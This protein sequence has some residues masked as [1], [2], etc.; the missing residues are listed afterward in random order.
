M[1]I[2]FENLFTSLSKTYYKQKFYKFQSLKRTKCLH[3]WETWLAN[4]DIIFLSIFLSIEEWIVYTGN[5]GLLSGIFTG[6]CELIKCGNK[7]INSPFGSCI[8]LLVNF[9]SARVDLFKTMIKY[10][11][12][13]LT[14]NVSIKCN[15]CQLNDLSLYFVNWTICD[16][17]SFVGWMIKAWSLSVD[18]LCFSFVCRLSDMSLVF[19]IWMIWIVFH[20]SIEW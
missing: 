9:G 6:I 2:S 14:S 3:F 18:D 15:I 5:N 12:G 10:S 20:L 7:V 16:W 17:V 11:Y 13:K 4:I 1:W 8:D 19:V